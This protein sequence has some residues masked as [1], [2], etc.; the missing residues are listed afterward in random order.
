MSKL[1][2]TE[3]WP[4][5]LPNDNG[6]RPAGP[7]DECFY[8]Q[9]KVG[10]AHGMRCVVVEKRVRYE[11]RLTEGRNAKVGTFERNDPHFWTPDDCQHHKNESSWCKSN[12]LDHIDWCV[13]NP[14]Q[15]FAAFTEESGAS[16]ACGWLTFVFD[17]VVDEGPLVELRD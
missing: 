15:L 4:M 17:C 8:C 10:Q 14:Q 16:C 7:P 3:G 9:R 13:D 5:V 2:K 6:I 1:V 12:A 11:V